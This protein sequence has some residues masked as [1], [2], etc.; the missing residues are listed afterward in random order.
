MSMPLDQQPPPVAIAQHTYNHSVHSSV[1]PVIAV[2]VVIIILGILAG[3]IGRLCSGKTIMGYGQYDIE[4]W[5]ESKCSTCIDGRITPPQPR[6]HLSS[7]TSQLPTP[8]SA[9]THQE[10]KPEEHQHSTPSPPTTHVQS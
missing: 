2:L 6:V 9:E 5:A 1:G 10:T 8:V 7:D 3:M 4:S